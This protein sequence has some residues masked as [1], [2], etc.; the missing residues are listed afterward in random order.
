M[1]RLAVVLLALALAG[2]GRGEGDAPVDPC[3]RVDFA[4]RDLVGALLRQPV[5]TGLF[6]VVAIE[7]RSKRSGGVGKLRLGDYTFKARGGDEGG[8]IVGKRGAKAAPVAGI[9]MDFLDA[10]A[11]SYT[12]HGK[13]FAGQLAVGKPT[14]GTRLPTTGKAHFSGPVRLELQDRRDG[15]TAGIALVGTADVEVRFGSRQVT[16]RLAGLAPEEAA[17][18]PL[19]VRALEWTGL[20]ICG[21][22]VGSTGQGGFR[23]LGPAGAPVNFAGPS[24]A[25]P[26]GSAVIDATFYGY[27]ATSA[28]PAGVGGILLI[29]GD[30]GVVAGIFAAERTN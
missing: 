20:G 8:G 11:V 26:S 5:G 4:K 15:G 29:Q 22:R 2:C 13:P 14:P 9:S 6:E 17:A 23:T 27:D 3:P 18:E 21:V 7:G 12:D 28:Q 24:D 30:D 19:P 10:Y 25:S 1:A 16:V